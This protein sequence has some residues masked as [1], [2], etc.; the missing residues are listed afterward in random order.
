MTKTDTPANPAGILTD[1]EADALT[2]PETDVKELT[3][4]RAR[5]RTRLTET[6]R[7][8]TVLYPTLPDEDLDTVFNPADETDQST[9][10]AATQDGLALLILGMLHGD[11]MVEMRVRDAF[12]NAGVSYGE[13]IDVTLKLRRSPLPT[14]EQFAA[15]VDSDGPTE[16]TLP[17]FE[18][19]LGQPDADMDTL[20]E[21]ASDLQIDITAADRDEI[22]TALASFERYPQTVVT[23]VTVTEQRQD[24]NREDGI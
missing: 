14:L 1:T 5:V 15:Q 13:E 12:V 20:E 22:Q 10:R 4:L 2:D 23:S 6:L 19:F 17:L 24:E 9:I 11:D 7:D 8:L 3:D 18:Y 16:Q 21:I